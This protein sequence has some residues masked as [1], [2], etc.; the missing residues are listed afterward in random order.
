MALSTY[1]SRVQ[2]DFGAVS[3]IQDELDYLGIVRPLVVTDPGVKNAQL[4]DRLVEH[5]NSDYLVYSDTPANP[6]E[7]AVLAALAVFSDGGC[8]GVVALGGGSP[9]DLAKAVALLHSHGG[10]INDYNVQTGGSAK[11]GDIT[12]IIAIPTTAGTGAEV[13]RACVMTL[14][15]G[16]KCNVVNLN[17]IPKTVIC[18]PELTLGL[19]PMITAATGID[20]LSHGIET[21]VSKQIN[22]PAE[23]LAL[24]CIRRIAS[25]IEKAYFDGTDRSAR[26]E[27]LA[28]ALE[29]GMVL[30]KGLGAVHALSDPLGE[31]K[32]HHGTLNAV[33]M[34]HVVELNRDSAREKY[35]TIARVIGLKDPDGLVDWLR[36]LN[37]TFSMPSSLGAMGVTEEVIPDIAGKAAR[38]HLSKTNPRPMAAEDYIGLLHGLL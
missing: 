32:L 6:T 3:L 30:Q 1:L 2:F 27:M 25:N 13:G 16:T 35:Q 26:W 34:P 11:I 23:G 12:P 20:A 4:L 33:I 24:D 7:Q 18:D 21:Y 22:P 29:G 28:G 8:D 17:L 36:D 31:L 10:L 15:D 9:I 14:A 5:M 37:T 38:T 19:P